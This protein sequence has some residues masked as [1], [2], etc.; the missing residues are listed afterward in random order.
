MTYIPDLKWCHLAPMV[1][2]GIFGPERKKSSGRPKWRLVDESLGKELD[3]S[4]MYCIP[5]KS[6]AMRRTA[7]ADKEEWDILDFAPGVK[8]RDIPVD[9]VTP[10]ARPI[11]KQ[12]VR[13]R[14]AIKP[15][16]GKIAVIKPIEA[17]P[18]NQEKQENIAPSPVRPTRG[19]PRRTPTKRESIAPSP[20]RPT[21][22]TPRRT[23]PLWSPPRKRS[24]P[25]RV[26]PRWTPTKQH[27]TNDLEPA[28]KARRL[29]NSGGRRS[30]LQS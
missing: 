24:T 15:M 20:V 10:T 19:T 14:S 30:V 27:G 6:K 11:K 29:N 25:S 7:D 3:I 23:S 21:R 18:A 26:S 16:S 28:R 9:L 1:Q 8:S 5:L 13:A 4:S 12:P 2:D 17:A 22:G